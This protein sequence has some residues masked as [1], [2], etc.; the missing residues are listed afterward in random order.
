MVMFC[1]LHTDISVHGYLTSIFLIVNI[2]ILYTS[3]D[4]TYVHA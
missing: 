1:I 3:Y 2:C 4:Y